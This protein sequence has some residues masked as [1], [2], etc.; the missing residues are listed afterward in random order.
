VNCVAPGLV[1]TDL[2]QALTRNEAMAKASAAM[3]PLG[4]IGEATEVASAMAW[5]MAPEQGWVTGQ[6]IGVDGGLG[7]VQSRG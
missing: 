1:R 2:T 7:R 3:H 4:R 5:L 6:V